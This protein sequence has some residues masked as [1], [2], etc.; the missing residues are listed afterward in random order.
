MPHWL[1]PGEVRDFF[2]ADDPNYNPLTPWEWARVIAFALVIGVT[3]GIGIVFLCVE[4]ASIW[5]QL[6]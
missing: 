3:L 2:N 4:L 1:Y 5:E 6:G